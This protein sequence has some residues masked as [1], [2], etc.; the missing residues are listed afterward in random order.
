MTNFA[1]DCT[2]KVQTDTYIWILI[3]NTFIWREYPYDILIEA[4][5]KTNLVTREV[6]LADTTGKQE[7]KA[8]LMFITTYNSANPNFR[9]L[10][11]KHW[12]YL[13]R[14]STTRELCNQDIMVTYMK[15][16]SLKDMLV[17]AK[18]PQPKTH[19]PKGCTRPS[20]CQYCTRLS[21][22][23]KIT[24]LNNNTT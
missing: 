21:Q 14:S 23:G 12:S 16:T 2:L 11:S 18:I 20:T 15:P 13:G 5:M 1:Q 7:S 4:W 19:T 9:E 22:S 6:L 3:Q 8:L 17:R 10:I 24:N